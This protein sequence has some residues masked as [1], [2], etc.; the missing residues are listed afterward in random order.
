[1]L[2]SIPRSLAHASRYNSRPLL[3]CRSCGG[4]TI[5]TSKYAADDTLATSAGTR[6]VD[7]SSLTKGY[8][9]LAL[10]APCGANQL[11]RLR[12]LPEILGVRAMSSKAAAKKVPEWKLKPV[13]PYMKG[14]QFCG[15]T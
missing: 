6:D 9:D 12:R 2:R 5:T 13:I 1:M 3:Q 10:G 8:A 14:E 15:I 11:T 4:A 7:I